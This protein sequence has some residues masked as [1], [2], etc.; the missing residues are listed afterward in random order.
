MIWGCMTSRVSRICPS[1]NSSFEQGKW[2]VLRK[3]REGKPITCRSCSIS[4]ASSARWAAT[5]GEGWQRNPDLTPDTAKRV[6]SVRRGNREHK[7]F[8][9]DCMAGC[10]REIRV[11]N[12]K[13][14]DASGNCRHCALRSRPFQQTLTALR[15]SSR[16]R[17]IPVDLSYEDMLLFTQQSECTYCGVEIPWVEWSV[18]GKSSQGY[19]LDRKD[20][21]KGYSVENCVVCCTSCNL[22]RG[23]RFTHEEFLVVGEAIRK[24]HQNRKG[25]TEF[26]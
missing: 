5:K 18:K 25:G 12:G 17:G 2:Y 8:I 14:R 1:C 4:K 6:E 26:T 16:H 22:T 23:D 3:E 19:F 7:V 13:F 24:I 15:C 21:T 11:G 20:N 10:G 9:F